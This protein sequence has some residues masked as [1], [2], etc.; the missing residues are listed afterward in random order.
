VARGHIAAS[1]DFD[2]YVSRRW[3]Q[4]VNAWL[5]VEFATNSMNRSMGQLDL[6]PFVLSPKVI[7]KLAFIHELTHARA[8]TRKPAL[9]GGQSPRF[10]AQSAGTQALPG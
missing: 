4:V 5:P 3:D 2:P 7:E 8:P 10:Q 9:A 1:I 6:Y